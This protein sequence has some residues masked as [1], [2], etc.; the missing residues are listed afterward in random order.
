[1]N[2][3]MWG[4]IWIACECGVTRFW[5]FPLCADGSVKDTF[6]LTTSSFH[7]KWRLDSETERGNSL[8]DFV[9]STSHELLI[10]HSLKLPKSSLLHINSL[11]LQFALQWNELYT[12]APTEGCTRNAKSKLLLREI[13]KHAYKVKQAAFSLNTFRK[14]T[15][16][17]LCIRRINQP[18]CASSFFGLLTRD[19]HKHVK[20]G[21]LVLSDQER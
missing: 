17:T 10:G 14:S 7:E 12:N 4:W 18:P 19:L 9:Q 13:S 8:R 6:S 16:F 3:G 2:L 15:F 5:C 11:C 20:S 21:A 1:M